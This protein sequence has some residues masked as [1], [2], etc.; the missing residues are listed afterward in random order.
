MDI[1]A[2][3]AAGARHLIQGELLS[4]VVPARRR[5]G[6]RPRR[7]RRDLR[8]RRHALSRLQ[9]GPDVLRTRPQQP[10]R[11]RGGTRRPRHAHSCE[12]GLFQRAPAPPRRP[13]GGDLRCAAQPLALHPVG[14]RFQRGGAALRPAR[15][16]AERHRRAAPELPRLHRRDPA[17][18][19]SLRPRPETGPRSRTCMRSPRPMP[20]ARP[21][22]PTARTGGAPLLAIAFDP[23]RPRVPQRSRRRHRRAAHQRGRG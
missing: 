16:R 12:L 14:R 13:P 22:G 19:A 3:R 15:H 18:S 17:P 7:R 6:L 1:A 23:A 10:A 9:L 20:I 4:D 8:F 11:D 5:A 2:L 21:W